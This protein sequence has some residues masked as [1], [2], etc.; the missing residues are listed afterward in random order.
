MNLHY[1]IITF[2]IFTSFLE[3]KNKSPRGYEISV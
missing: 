1:E 3:N 2:I